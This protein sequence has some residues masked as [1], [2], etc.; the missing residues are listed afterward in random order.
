MAD[1]LKSLLVAGALA[2]VPV[3]QAHAAQPLAQTQIVPE[4]YVV[5]AWELYK[6]T[7]LEDGRIVDRSNGNIS[8]S[9]GQGYGM[10]ISVVADDRSTFD[11]IW[12]WTQKEL[13]VRGDKLA[14][15]KWD[16]EASP[17]A[18]DLNN[19][20]DG[21]LLIAWALMRAGQKWKEASY[22]EA[23]RA[24]AGAI[25]KEAVID[26][27]DNGKVLLPAVKGFAASEQPDGPVVNLSY[28][29]FPAIRDLGTISKDFPA[30]ALIR[31]GT[32][33]L[34]TARFGSS[35][36][37]SDWISLKG[38]YPQPAQKFAKNFGYDAIRIPL[39]AAWYGADEA[40]LL[41]RVNDRWKVGGV[42]AVQVVE[43]ATAAPL[44]AMPDPGYQ[45]VS[46][47][48]ACSLG[49]TTGLTAIGD[50]QPTEYYPSTLH[51]ISLVAVSERYPQCLQKQN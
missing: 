50:F 5:G 23:A 14:A 11:A 45:A 49:K 33:L 15:W 22:T 20:T 51:L 7:F 16:P 4:D 39:Y 9:E 40:R 36:L 12:N 29:I 19:A 32:G 41:G 8:H 18:S 6:A 24:I 38:E 10:L 21:D 42:N 35:Q 28:W 46:D 37:P 31:S 48:L 30:E 27:G 25:T 43:L 47:L 2:L 13:Y 26:D 34:K 1:M 3:A 44:V 17:H